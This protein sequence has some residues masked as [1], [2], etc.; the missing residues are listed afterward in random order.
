MPP[1][2]KVKILIEVLRIAIEKGYKGKLPNREEAIDLAMKTA[3]PEAFNDKGFWRVLFGEK[4]L[5]THIANLR[6]LSPDG[7][8]WYLSNTFR[9]K[10]RIT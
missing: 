2:I 5:Q 3:Y 10:R 6:K 8:Y 4:Y 9:I 7:I 1:E